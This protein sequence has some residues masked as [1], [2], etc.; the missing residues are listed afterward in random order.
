MNRLVNFDKVCGVIFVTLLVLGAS[1]LG[2]ATEQAATP[3]LAGGIPQI[4]TVSDDGDGNIRI[5]WSL[6]VPEGEVLSTTGDPD[7]IHVSWQAATRGNSKTL[8]DATSTDP[9]N[10]LV[11][12]TGI[13]DASWIVE[14]TYTVTLSAKYPGYSWLAGLP[15]GGVSVTVQG[16][17]SAIEAPAED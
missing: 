6:H 17:G 1:Q 8:S 7:Q 2:W 12:D 9:S 13:G 10:D 3:T 15:E 4:D 5:S 16:G 14:D 11:V